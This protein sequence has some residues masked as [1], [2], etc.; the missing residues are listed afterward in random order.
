MGLPWADLWKNWVAMHGDGSLWDKHPPTPYL[1]SSIYVSLY[2]PITYLHLPFSIF[3]FFEIINFTHFVLLQISNLTYF[4]YFVEI[5]I[6]NQQDIYCWSFF[7]AGYF[8][9][10]RKTNEISTCI[11][12]KVGGSCLSE[13]Y[14]I[15]LVFYT[16][17]N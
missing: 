9:V 17:F 1:P 12:L 2:I 5:V 13:F 10:K 14:I 11:F 8:V 4:S 3:L 15:Y 16:F 7:L 6:I